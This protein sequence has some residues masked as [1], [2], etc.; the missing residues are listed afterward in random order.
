MMYNIFP[1]EQGTEICPTIT[2]QLKDVRPL[3][4]DPGAPSVGKGNGMHDQKPLTINEAFDQL[5]EVVPR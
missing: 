4:H 3:Q 2:V 1:I 5:R